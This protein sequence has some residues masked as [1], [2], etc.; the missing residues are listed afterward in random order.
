[1]DSST[2][3]SVLKTAQLV[4]ENMCA[5]EGGPVSA[6][7][8]DFDARARSLLSNS[9]LDFENIREAALAGDFQQIRIE[10]YRNAALRT[11]MAE[12]NQDRRN[13]IEWA[14]DQIKG[15]LPDGMKKGELLGIWDRLSRAQKREIST[16]NPSGW[17]KAVCGVKLEMEELQHR[18][19]MD[20]YGGPAADVGLQTAAAAELS[21]SG[22]DWGNGNDHGQ[23]E[24]NNLAR[25]PASGQDRCLAREAGSDPA[26]TDWREGGSEGEGGGGVRGGGFHRGCARV[27]PRGWG[28]WGGVSGRAGCVRDTPPCSSPHLAAAGLAGAL[29]WASLS[30]HWRKGGVRGYTSVG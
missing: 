17:F 22:Q 23:G 27:V 2:Y 12:N 4:Y 25:E 9:Y 19:Q 7:V 30:S 26:R 5:R 21:D 15:R 10:Y 1:M 28:G 14:V 6:R 18:A 20:L 8:R 3:D 16:V 11:A 13:F 29:E 24:S